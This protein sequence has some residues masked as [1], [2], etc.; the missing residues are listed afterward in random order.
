MEGAHPKEATGDVKPL[1]TRRV[2][3]GRRARV[4]D[5]V[6]GMRDPGKLRVRV[7]LTFVRTLRPALYVLLLTSAL[8]TFW[9]GGGLGGRELPRWAAS[10]A[11]VLFA[12]FLVVFAVYRLALVR[13]KKYPAA[14]GLFQIGLGALVWVLLLPGTRQGI[15]REQGDWIF[16][17]DPSMS[18]RHALVRSEDADFVVLDANSRNG[19]AI[20]A[21]GDVSLAHD[22]RILVGDKLLR[23][24]I[25]T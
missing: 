15:G 9:A 11:P 4:S 6:D 3:R 10:A 24:E 22:S 8:L 23:I 25:P 20:A 17:Y 18:A 14:M 1:W 7:G 2:A 12:V 13:A 5:A 19:V 16:P 21:R